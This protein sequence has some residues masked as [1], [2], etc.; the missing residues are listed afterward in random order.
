[1]LQLLQEIDSPS[2]IPTE[3]KYTSTVKKERES[4]GGSEGKIGLSFGSSS[5]GLDGGIGLSKKY[6]KDYSEMEIKEITTNLPI[7]LNKV[8]QILIDIVNILNI[9]QLYV[10]IDE[11]AE[12]DKNLNLGI[13]PYFAQLLKMVFFNERRFS[14]KI[15]SIWHRTDLY[16]RLDMNKSKGLELGEDIELGVDLDSAFIDDEQDIVEFYKKVLFKR[17]SYLLPEICQQ[18]ETNNNIDNIFI[19]E[20]FDEIKNFKFLVAASH[21]IPRDFFEIFNKCTLKIDRNFSQYCIDRDLIDRTAQ[22]IFLIEKRKSLDKNSYAQSLYDRINDYMDK[23]QQRFFLVKNEEAKNSSP[24]RKLCDEELIHPIPSAITP[25]FIR[26]KYKVFQIDY[27]N[28]VDW[29]KS[30]KIPI[31]KIDES[32]TP[33]FPEDF[34]DTFNKYLIEI[35]DLA[36]SNIKCKFCNKEFSE[37]NPVFKKLGGCPYCGEKLID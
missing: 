36:Q 34:P 23:T 28:C 4:K 29:I 8:R 37:K 9:D 15:A 13:Q 31:E 2:P 7:N 27:G 5:F 18:M 14:V 16:D 3:H 10:L 12:M 25:R 17:I 11:W 21:G 20:L 35:N 1:M 22:D 6:N 26:D 30:K 32:V 33:K 19:E 24:L